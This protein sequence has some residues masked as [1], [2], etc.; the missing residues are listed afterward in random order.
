MAPKKQIMSVRKGFSTWGNRFSCLGISVSAGAP[1]CSFCRVVEVRDAVCLN[2][3]FY[4][5]LAAIH[6]RFR[7][8]FVPLRHHRNADCFAILQPLQGSYDI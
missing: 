7:G 4:K 1:T 8:H 2:P 3:A 6:I 5:L